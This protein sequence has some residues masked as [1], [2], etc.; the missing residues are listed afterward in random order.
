MLNS[1]SSR[2]HCHSEDIVVDVV[3]RHSKV[4]HIMV[5]DGGVRAF[6][7]SEACTE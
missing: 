3:F 4:G 5:R 2:K 7:L 6:L 1:M